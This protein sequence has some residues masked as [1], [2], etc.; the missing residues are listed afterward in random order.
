M[1]LINSVFVGKKS[2]YLSKCAVKKQLKPHTK[3]TIGRN[4]E[5]ITTTTTPSIIVNL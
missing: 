3:F 4:K 1:F 5:D 2:L